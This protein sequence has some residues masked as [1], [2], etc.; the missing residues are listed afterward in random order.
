[1][2]PKGRS[3]G[4]LLSE[5]TTPKAGFTD[6]A[7]ISGRDRLFALGLC[8]GALLTRRSVRLRVFCSIEPIKWCN[9]WL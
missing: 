7:R 1:V 3:G 9:L 6:I 5:I 4:L 8:V 2:V